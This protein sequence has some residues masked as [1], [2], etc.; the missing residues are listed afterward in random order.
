[1]PC[2]RP[3]LARPLV[4]VLGVSKTVVQGSVQSQTRLSQAMLSDLNTIQL[5]IY[6][7]VF[8]PSFG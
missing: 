1:M 6:V 7:K 4:K 5:K 2:T 3:I 8:F